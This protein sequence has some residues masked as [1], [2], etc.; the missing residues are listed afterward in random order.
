MTLFD[1]LGS[2]GFKRGQSFLASG[3]V[4]LFVF[5]CWFFLFV[6]LFVCLL[7]LFCFVFVLF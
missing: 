5:C 3:F 7:V 6:C 2:H 1:A 4:C